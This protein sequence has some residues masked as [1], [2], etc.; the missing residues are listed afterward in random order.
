MQKLSVR[1][2]DSEELSAE[3]GD[4]A[5]LRELRLTDCSLRSLPAT[6]PRLT[7][8]ELL[9][10]RFNSFREIP[11][12]IGQITNLQSLVLIGNPLQ[13][14]IPASFGNLT[15]L[16]E[17]ILMENLETGHRLSGLLPPELGNMAS[18]ETL[19]LEGNFTGP[20]PAQF[21]D[22]ISLKVLN[23]YG[24]FTD[25]PAEIGRLRN[26]VDLKIRGSREPLYYQ[27]APF[28]KIPAEIGGLANL[29]SLHLVGSATEI[30]PELGNLTA[31]TD[32]WLTVDS[33]A[34]IPKELGNLKALLSLRLNGG[35]TGVIPAWICDLLDLRTLDLSDNQLE[36]KI[37]VELAGLSSVWVLKLSHNRLEGNIPYQIVDKPGYRVFDAASN[38]LSGP[39][40][41]QLG[42]IASG[43]WVDWRWNALYPV[44]LSVFQFI[45]KHHKGDFGGTQSYGPVDVTAT[46][47]GNTVRLSW[48]PITY[49][50]DSGGYEILYRERE[51]EPWSVCGMTTS[52]RTTSYTVTGLETGRQYFFAVRTVTYPHANNQNTVRGDPGN[53]V[54]AGTTASAEA[55]FP[56]Y[57]DGPGQFTGLAITNLAGGD[58]HGQLHALGTGGGQ[59]V[60]PRN[61]AA[62]SLPVGRQL[63]RVQAELFGA[64]AAVAPWSMRLDADQTPVTLCLQGGPG[65]LDGATGLAGQHK[66]LL[67]PRVYEGAGVLA[68][69]TAVTRINLLN[70][71]A[72]GVWVRLRLISPR[73]KPDI[74]GPPIV[75]VEVA[76]RIA[77]GGLL[78]ETLTELFSPAQPGAEAYLEVLSEGEGVNGLA[79]VTVGQGKSLFVV[80]GSPPSG[81]NELSAAQVAGGSHIATSVRLINTDSIG[82]VVTL[83]LYSDAESLRQET[84]LEIPAGSLIDRDLSALFQ[85]TGNLTAG[86]LQASANGTGVLGD[87]LVYGPD[88]EYASVTQLSSRPAREAVCGYLANGLGVFT[89]LALFNPGDESADVA[90]EVFSSEGSSFGKASISLASKGRL[91]RQTSELVPSTKGKVGGYVRITATQPIIV[92]EMFAAD[93]LEYMSTVPP[94][95][96]K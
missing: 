28:K 88:G 96:L 5:N 58:M 31:L 7:K 16:K 80:A 17:L 19:I 13:G 66:R 54:I 10:L 85:L 20:I 26:L 25:V 3:V 67:F 49:Q 82:R 69:Q 53:I 8:L 52:K 37:P 62:V 34:P 36:G 93:T 57:P 39:L 79:V 45:S 84:T 61:P 4:M 2:L 60:F 63:A 71:D 87:I 72:T 21:G 51:D 42:E 33:P 90:V 94:V 29:T 91:A 22:L 23:L 46:G 38:R 75:S 59:A 44:E 64:D 32:L 9:D 27:K 11:A 18:L 48:S 95:I 56:L 30:P 73:P 41:R 65:L 92:Q 43:T 12:L 76:R 1:Y 74:I 89:G 35:L 78:S 24:Q 47:T 55:W 86:S 81:S 15:Q 14:P 77:P 6:L 40:P 50:S 68:G 70:P 83:R